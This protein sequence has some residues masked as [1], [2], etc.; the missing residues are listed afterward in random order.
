[1]VLCLLQGVSSDLGLID[2]GCAVDQ[3]FSCITPALS[4]YA[5]AYACIWDVCVRG[6]HVCVYVPSMHERFGVGSE[7]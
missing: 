6:P 1:M 7:N 4:V 3:G 2:P 5:H